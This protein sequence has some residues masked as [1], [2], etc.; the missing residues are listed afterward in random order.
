M[1]CQGVCRAMER[2]AAVYDLDAEA[3]RWAG[4]MH[5]VAKELPD[6]ELLRLL[7]KFYPEALEKL[8][9]KYRVNTYLHGPAGAVI[10]RKLWEYPNRDVVLAIE[11]HAGNHLDMSLLSR[12]LHVADLTAPV[13][14]YPGRDKLDREFMAGRLDHAELLAD[15]WTVEY[16]LER[17]IPVHPVYQEKIRRLSAEVRPTRD[18]F[19]RSLA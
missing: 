13:C 3:A 17:N 15:T 1:H 10:M 9:E 14:D 5:D 4:L 12:C 16:F 6:Q 11:Q 19:V 7:G 8:P 2:A 18:F